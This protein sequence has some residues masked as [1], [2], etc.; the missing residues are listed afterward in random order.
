MR[1]DVS[2]GCCCYRILFDSLEQKMTMDVVDLQ[3]LL[4]MIRTGDSSGGSRVGV[5]IEY[6]RLLAMLG[7]DVN[8]Q[9]NCK[10]NQRLNKRNSANLKRQGIEGSNE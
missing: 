9:P 10:A 3:G 8:L 4:S 1:E 6:S 2:H 5:M 7:G